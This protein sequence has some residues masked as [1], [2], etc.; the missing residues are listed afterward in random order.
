[1]KQ[2]NIKNIFLVSALSCFCGLQ[3]FN[4]SVV[5]AHSY[6]S[7]D[8]KTVSLD[9]KIR[10]INDKRYFDNISSLSKTFTNGDLIEFYIKVTN[11][12]DVNLKNIKVTDNLPPFLKL[13]FHPGKY[14]STDNKI[15]W[16]IYELNPG[17]S[18]KFLIR[19]K[20]DQ[21]NYVKT[22]T[23]ETNVASLWVDGIEARDDATYYILTKGTTAVLGKSDNNE[24]VVPVAGSSDLIFQTIGVI[25]IGLGG[26]TLRK[27]IRGY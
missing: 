24:I 22:L 19:A 15:E 12:G 6:S 7:D 20:I 14:N 25:G 2:V 13:I 11:T 9:K 23:K 18:Q 16:E 5:K 1:M 3:L 21:A 10:S 4:P 17:H 26:L 27:K 8:Q